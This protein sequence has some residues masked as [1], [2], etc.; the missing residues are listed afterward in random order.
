MM[1]SNE[2]ED[3]DE[4]VDAQEEIRSEPD[5]E[6]VAA[7]EAS[8]DDSET[9]EDQRAR[10]AANEKAMRELEEEDLFESTFGKKV[11]EDS[12]GDDDDQHEKNGEKVIEVAEEVK[13]SDKGKA[14]TAGGTGSYREFLKSEH[15][16][17]CKQT[18]RMST[19]PDT[20][21]PPPPPAG[22]KAPD[23]IADLSHNS[24]WLKNFHNRAVQFIPRLPL[25]THR[26][27]IGVLNLD[28][29]PKYFNSEKH[30]TWMKGNR[31]TTVETVWNM[32][33]Q[34]TAT[35]DFVLL[36][37]FEKVEDRDRVE[38]LDYFNCKKVMFRAVYK[39][40]PD[41][42]GRELCAGVIPQ[43]QEVA[44]QKKIMSTEVIEID[45]D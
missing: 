40:H 23:P 37:G 8:E 44:K 1:V 20:G 28:V 2:N 3:D 21:L 29:K 30:F 19:P 34:T 39:S 12:D 24:K 11:A 16:K 36:L 17:G 35:E 31:F 38:E 25:A 14:S 4:F 15:R 33:Q 6:S 7:D 32:Y 43:V 22:P 42:G 10:E 5:S 41:A 26:Y 13:S 9:L 18:R 45:D 27:W